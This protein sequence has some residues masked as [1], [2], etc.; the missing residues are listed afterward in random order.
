MLLVL[1][2]SCGAATKK[3][4]ASKFQLESDHYVISHLRYNT[5][6]APNE[7]SKYDRTWVITFDPDSE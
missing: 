6:G 1:L 5:Y 3:N 2:V 4:S 7:Y